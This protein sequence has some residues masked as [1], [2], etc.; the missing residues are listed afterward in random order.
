MTILDEVNKQKQLEQ[1]IKNLEL[2][3]QKLGVILAT[4][5]Q[6]VLGILL[7]D[8]CRELYDESRKVGGFKD[9]VFAYGEGEKNDH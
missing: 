8:T 2:A 5:K 7:H 9:V 1:R 3:I 6:P 4:E